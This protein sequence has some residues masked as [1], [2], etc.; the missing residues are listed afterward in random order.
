MNTDIMIYLIVNALRVGLAVYFLSIFLEKKCPLW[1]Y[2]VAGMI[3]WGVN[4][5]AYLV[6]NIN[7]LTLASNLIGL[8]IIALTGYKGRFLNTVLVLLLDITVGIAAESIAYYL[9]VHSETGIR[10]YADIL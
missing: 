9:F 3:L 2:A 1:F 10:S 6:I 7:W 5:F 8:G 4:S